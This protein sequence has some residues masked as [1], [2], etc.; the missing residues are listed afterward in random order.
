MKVPCMCRAGYGGQIFSSMFDIDSGLADNVSPAL[1]QV[2][3]PDEIKLMFR[4][5]TQDISLSSD[6]KRALSSWIMR[7]PRAM[8]VFVDFGRHAFIVLE[9]EIIVDSMMIDDCARYGTATPHVLFSAQMLTVGYYKQPIISYDYPP[10]DYPKLNVFLIPPQSLVYWDGDKFAP[11][12]IRCDVK[13]N[14]NAI[15]Y[16]SFVENTNASTV[17]IVTVNGTPTFIIKE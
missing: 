9:N 1:L 13:S 5:I 7:E 2:R 6:T 16:P 3:L 15:D 11:F 8:L 10:V 12:P 17:G 4:N 14:Y